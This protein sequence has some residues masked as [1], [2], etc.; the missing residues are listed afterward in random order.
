MINLVFFCWPPMSLKTKLE[1]PGW[2][3]GVPSIPRNHEKVQKYPQP[4][5]WAIIFRANPSKLILKNIM[6][7]Y[8]CF[9][10]GLLSLL[11]IGLNSSSKNNFLNKFCFWYGKCQNSIIILQLFLLKNQIN[12][13]NFKY[14]KGR[15]KMNQLRSD[16]LT[17]NQKP[18]SAIDKFL[19]RWK[20][21]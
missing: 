3:H 2:S 15:G 10:Y 17:T 4:V 6:F 16:R 14:C 12:S 19:H 1:P 21:K 20:R 11:S 9:V 13:D 8:T 7:K 5:K 18:E